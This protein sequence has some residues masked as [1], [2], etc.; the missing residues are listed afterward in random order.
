MKRKELIFWKYFARFACEHST[1]VYI[2]SYCLH[3]KIAIFMYHQ[4]A[5]V[6]IFD[7]FEDRIRVKSYHTI[8]F[9]DPLEVVKTTSD[10]INFD[11]FLKKYPKDENQP[12]RE[13]EKTFDEIIDILAKEDKIQKTADL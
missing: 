10:G 4:D 9:P 5:Y 12:Y 3:T 8:D 2:E 6:V 11:E 13:Y 1:K 7:M